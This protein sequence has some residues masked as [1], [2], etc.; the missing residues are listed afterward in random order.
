M[1]QGCGKWQILQL[2][3][4]EDGGLTADH[5]QDVGRTRPANR[6]RHGKVMAAGR[7]RHGQLR[8]KKRMATDVAI[9]RGQRRVVARIGQG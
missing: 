7:N 9:D 6:G 1:D 5:G 4:S 3:C 8:R 2:A